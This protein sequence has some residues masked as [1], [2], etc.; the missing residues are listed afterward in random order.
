[1]TDTNKF[2]IPPNR[3]KELEGLRLELGLPANLD[4]FNQALTILVWAIAEKKKGNV[5]GSIDV[6]T[7]EYMEFDLPVFK[8]LVSASAA[9]VE[10]V[11]VVAP[12][13]TQ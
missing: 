13:P 3:V 7:S 11:D 1:M 12:R 9:S 5:I 10:Q 2:E 4:V 8:L 6:T